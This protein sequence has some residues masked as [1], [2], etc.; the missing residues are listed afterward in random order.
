MKRLAVLCLVLV[1]CSAATSTQP[2]DNDARICA[3]ALQP[4]WNNGLMK[5]LTN[6]PQTP[7]EQQ[8][9]KVQDLFDVN[10]DSTPAWNEL[11]RMCVDAGY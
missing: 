4:P 3:A 11:S 1:A 2:S 9:R 8:A 10:G 5:A 7:I 6:S